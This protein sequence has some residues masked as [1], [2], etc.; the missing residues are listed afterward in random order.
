MPPSLAAVVD[1]YLDGWFVD[2]A[3]RDRTYRDLRRFDEP[4]VDLDDAS[5]A[6]SELVP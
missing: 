5:D 2:A 3:G 6:V 4:P 1:G